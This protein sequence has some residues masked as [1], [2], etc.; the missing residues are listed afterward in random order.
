MRRLLALV[1]GAVLLIVVAVGPAAAQDDGISVTPAEGLLDGQVVEIS[2]STAA[3]DFGLVAL[4]PSDSAPVVGDG[5][6]TLIPKR[7]ICVGLLCM[8]DE[9]DTP[10]AE[11]FAGDCPRL[12]Q[13]RPISAVSASVALPR[14]TNDGTDCAVEEC[15]IM[16][17]TW[18]ISSARAVVSTLVVFDETVAAPAAVPSE[19]T[20]TTV[21]ST[22]TLP[23]ETTTTVGLSAP[24][25]TSTIP[26]SSPP[27]VST[28]ATT[29]PT[30]VLGTQ[31]TNGDGELAV[32]G[33][34]AGALAALGLSLLVVGR[35]A[36][37]RSRRS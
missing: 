26:P 17:S 9:I 36:V 8:H 33:F 29:V 24:T 30:Q 21:A 35:G 3:A 7:D 16:F 37:V 32:T 28:P 18:T 6:L 12:V 5:P 2:A 34:D 14:F 13:P 25:A 27:S 22:T 15:V 23:S 1:P 31:E 10:I 19:T 20:T 4:C 11:L